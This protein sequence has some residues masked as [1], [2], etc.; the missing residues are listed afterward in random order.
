M[1]NS[2]VD[3]HAPKVVSE[4][5]SIPF[6]FEVLLMAEIPNNHLGCIKPRIFHGIFTIS[7][8]EFTG[9]QPSTVCLTESYT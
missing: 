8:G 6:I 3:F 9:F 1:A 5:V 2:D 4:G 7:N